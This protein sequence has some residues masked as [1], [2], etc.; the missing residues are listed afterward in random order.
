M[1]P[2]Y[3]LP[4]MLGLACLAILWPPALGLDNGVGLTPPMGWSSWNVYAG[5]VDEAKIKATIDAM[6]TMKDAGYE[7]VNIDDNWMEATL[8]EADRTSKRTKK[9]ADSGKGAKD[10]QLA[11]TPAQVRDPTTWTILQND[12]PNQFGL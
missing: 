7:Y 10:T 8:K 6:A 3:M 5:G 2:R 9:L 11:L 1:V 4:N 12:G